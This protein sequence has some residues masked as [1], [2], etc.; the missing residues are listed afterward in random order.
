VRARD[1]PN[2]RPGERVTLVTGLPVEDV[3]PHG[4]TLRR[5][6]EGEH[7]V[8]LEPGGRAW[9]VTIGRVHVLPQPLGTVLAQ[10]LD[11]RS[12]LAGPEGFAAR[13]GVLDVES[14]TTDDFTLD[15]LEVA[16]SLTRTTGMADL[17]LDAAVSRRGGVEVDPDALDE[18][19]RRRALQIGGEAIPLGAILEPGLDRHAE[20]IA[21]HARM[22]WGN[23]ARRPD[24]SLGDRRRPRPSR[25]TPRS[26]ATP[27]GGTPW[28][29]SATASAGPISQA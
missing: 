10:L 14:Q 13:V 12:Q 17:R 6:L 20:A 23:Q 7:E 4:G 19:V 1:L 18:P 9:R 8:R 16:R 11:P 2:E 3:G 15:G 29:T 21:A 28:G 22:R 27:G 26:C 24:P 25:R 5:H